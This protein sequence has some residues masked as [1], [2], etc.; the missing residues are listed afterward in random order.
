MYSSWWKVDGGQVWSLPVRVVL[1]GLLDD[2]PQ[3]PTEAANFSYY[4]H[5]L[6]GK[7]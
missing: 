1:N 7:E 5:Q 6:L 2:V 4:T 3:P